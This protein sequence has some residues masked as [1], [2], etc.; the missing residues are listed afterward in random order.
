VDHAI[1]G[2]YGVTLSERSIKET[3]AMLAGVMGFRQVGEVGNRYRFEVG[4]DEASRAMID[5]LDLPDTPPGQVSVGS[6]HHIAWR[7]PSDEE[8][9]QW[10][11]EIRSTGVNVTPV[12]DRQYFHSI[13]YREPGG[14]LFEIATD[15]PGFTADESS[16]EL[17]SQIKL[18]PWLEPRRPQLEQRLQPLKVPMDS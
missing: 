8:Q 1:R 4:Q 9:L 15:P 10:Q 18:P 17:G 13:Y 3:E 7:T 12:M 16:E 6:V 5:L 14:V 11:Q 2:F